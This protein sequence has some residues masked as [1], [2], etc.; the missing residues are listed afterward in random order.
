MK[1]RLTRGPG[2]PTED[3]AEGVERYNVMLDAETVKKAREVGNGSLSV[4]IR[5]MFAESSIRQVL[6]NNRN[7]K[8]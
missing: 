2:R 6:D 3:G 4:G 7:N 1:R 5:M 8:E